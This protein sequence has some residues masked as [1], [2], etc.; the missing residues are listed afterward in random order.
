M[1]GSNTK[2][3]II[4]A[5]VANSAIAGAKLLAALVT[6][7]SAMLAEGIHSIADAANQVLL[8]IGI[9]RSRRPPDDQH[10]LGYGKTIYVWS[11]IVAIVLFSLGGMYSLNE[12][13]HKLSDPQPLAWPWLAIS[14]LVFAIIAE[15]ISLRKA[16][17]EINKVRGDRS[18]WR[19][20]RES[21]ASELVVIFGEDVAAEMGLL[22]ALAAVAMTMLT[23][24]PVYD[25]LGTLAIGLL[26]VVIA[27][28][29]GV[30]V[31]ALLIGESTDPQDIKKMRIFIGNRPEIEDLLNLL[32]IQL[33]HD[34][35]VSAK[36]KMQKVDS[37]TDLVAAIN[38][39][40]VDFKQ[41]FPQVVWLFVEP[42]IQV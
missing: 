35:M 36:L 18:L 41:A 16:I 1:A 17:I 22:L 37:A 2:S 39:F 33:G 21:R 15:G 6:G 19:W 23:G 40:E 7:S 26:L 20:F 10:P 3:A 32:T 28:L 8:L 27:L 12:G 11:F 38:R 14:I 9:K 4:Y 31:K 42:D 29:I 34:V 25:A 30:E 24:N 5:L 13:W